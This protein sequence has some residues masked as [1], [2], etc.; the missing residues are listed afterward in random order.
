MFS[1]KMGQLQQAPPKQKFKEEFKNNVRVERSAEKYPLDMA[2]L[3]KTQTD[4]KEIKLGQNCASKEPP[5]L[6]RYWQLMALR[7]VESFFF[8]SV[9]TGRFPTPQ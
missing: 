8:R 2:W 3:L 9:D 5:Q 6:R 1:P 4:Y 7:G